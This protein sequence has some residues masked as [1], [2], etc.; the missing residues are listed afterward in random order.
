MSETKENIVERLFKKLGKTAEEAGRHAKEEAG[1]MNHKAS[2]T[3]RQAAE[4]IGKRVAQAD[5]DIAGEA[6][7]AGHAIKD[8]VR[9]TSHE[10]EKE[11]KS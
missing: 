6:A 11:E 7:A 9:A 3:V 8:A 10:I 2:S 4:D 1:E 5:S